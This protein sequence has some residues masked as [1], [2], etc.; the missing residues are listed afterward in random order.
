MVFCVKY[1]KTKAD[2][3]SKDVILKEYSLFDVIASGEVKIMVPDN[4]LPTRDIQFNPLMMDFPVQFE[5][6][7][8]KSAFEAVFGV[9]SKPQ[10]RD[11][12]YFEQFMNRMYEVD[13]IAEADDFMYT[14]SYWRVSLVTYQ[15]RTNVLYDGGDGASAAQQAI[16]EAIEVETD[17]LTSNVEDKFRVE[18]ENQF[19]DVRKPNEYNTIGSQANDYVRRAL[20]RKMS[21]TEE[22]VYNNWTIISKYH[23]AL[24]TLS[25]RSLAVKYRYKNGWTSEEDRAFTFWF[26]PQFTKPI[27]KNILIT[28]IGNNAGFPELTTPGLPDAP[29]SDVIKKRRLV[30]YKRD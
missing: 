23:Y 25:D 16:S 6:H 30:S 29:V 22:N 27:Q 15:K 8:V 26:R 9:G 24:G 20:N 4:E 28:A 2:Q 11:Y 21:I 3:R 7:I 17:A 13:A 19:K 12:L 10:M 18:R 1:Y 14:G 5:I